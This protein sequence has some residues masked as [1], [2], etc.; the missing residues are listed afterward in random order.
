MVILIGQQQRY[1]QMSGRC[2][3]GSA[4]GK[5]IIASN[6]QQMDTPY[7]NACLSYVGGGGKDKIR[8]LCLQPGT[9]NIQSGL[10]QY[11]DYG[12]HVEST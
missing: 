3:I 2:G 1:Q 7:T 11:A 9:I 6:V 12:M 5:M 4:A 10:Y 8:D